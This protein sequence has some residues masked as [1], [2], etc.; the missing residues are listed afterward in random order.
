MPGFCAETRHP[1]CQ[2]PDTPSRSTTAKQRNHS[3]G[4]P[5]SRPRLADP[6][7]GRDRATLEVPEYRKPA[8]AS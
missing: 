3:D 4:P 2:Q 8:D 6:E 5:T 1:I 7:A